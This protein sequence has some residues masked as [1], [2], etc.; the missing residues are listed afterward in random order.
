MSSPPPIS[1]E[2]AI[3]R[4]RDALGALVQLAVFFNDNHTIRCDDALQVIG[5]TRCI[6]GHEG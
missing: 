5:E 6:H 1:S 4:V 3:R 2:S